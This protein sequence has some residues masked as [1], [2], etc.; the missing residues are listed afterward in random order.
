MINVAVIRIPDY[1][2]LIQL[3]KE[4]SLQAVDGFGC[5]TCVAKLGLSIIRPFKPDGECLAWIRDN[6][7]PRAEVIPLILEVTH[8]RSK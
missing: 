1:S 3:D 8:V 7:H 4:G 5:S 2:F 6:A